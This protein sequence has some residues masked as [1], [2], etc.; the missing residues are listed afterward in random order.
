MLAMPQYI[1]REV[2]AVPW[3]LPIFNGRCDECGFDKEVAYFAGSTLCCDCHNMVTAKC[4]FADAEGECPSGCTQCEP[5]HSRM[6][7]GWLAGQ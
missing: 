5:E 1:R 2:S 3:A 4:D 6:L 7:E